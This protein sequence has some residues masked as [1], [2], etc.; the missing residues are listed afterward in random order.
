[1]NSTNYSKIY[2]LL[3]WSIAISIILLL[4]T[5]FLRST[6]MN[7]NNMAEIIQNYLSNE[8]ISIN[9]KQS[10]TLAKQ[11]REPMWAWHIYIGYVITAL[12]GI[13]F[14]VPFFG[15]MKIQNPLEKNL[16][17]K[18]RFQKWTYIIFYIGITMSLI[19]GL[20]MMFGPDELAGKAEK[21]HVLALYYL[22]PFILVHIAGVF[23]AEYT[24]QKGIIYR[25][26][27]GKSIHNS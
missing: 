10:I 13:R 26:I 27:R 1:M 20:I 21:K 19:T 14:I 24:N 6:W 11:I 18:V 15:M 23:I 5:I 9:E 8:G 7:K 3:H 25:I 4:I 17:M 2:R 22:I 16:T 12:I